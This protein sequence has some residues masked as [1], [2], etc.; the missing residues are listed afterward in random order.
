MRMDD[1]PLLEALE[2]HLDRCLE[3]GLIHEAQA[4]ACL[5]ALGAVQYAGRNGAITPKL[6]TRLQAAPF[7]Q[8]HS[9]S[10][11]LRGAA[12]LRTVPSTSNFSVEEFVALMKASNLAPD[13]AEAATMLWALVELD[14]AD[15]AIQVREG[16]AT[17]PML[18]PC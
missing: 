2:T 3:R 8:P 9:L 1:R 15:V 12:Q 14:R 17:L 4:A 16:M 7:L 5:E 6:L 10:A 11:L 13:W 18:T